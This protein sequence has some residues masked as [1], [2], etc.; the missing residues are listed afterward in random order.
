[1]DLVELDQQHLKTLSL[2][3]R[4]FLLTDELYRE[5]A[6]PLFSPVAI[7]SRM[8]FSTATAPCGPAYYST[9]GIFFDGSTVTQPEAVGGQA[10]GS[11]PARDAR[12]RAVVLS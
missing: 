8:L 10:A 5:S 9:R 6:I 11:T 4:S 2:L 3:S 1:M 12:T 7:Y